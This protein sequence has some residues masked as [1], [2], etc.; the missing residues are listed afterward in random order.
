MSNSRAKYEEL[1]QQEHFIDLEV[2]QRA[3]H[4]LVDLFKAAVEANTVETF[5]NKAQYI[6]NNAPK[7]SPVVVFQIAADEAKVDELRN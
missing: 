3:V 4:I 5:L 6:S 1:R 7:L 2:N